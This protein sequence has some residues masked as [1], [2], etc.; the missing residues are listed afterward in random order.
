MSAL[1]T[2][3]CSSLTVFSKSASFLSTPP[4]FSVSSFIRLSMVTTVFLSPSSFA[5]LSAA[6]SAAVLPSSFCMSDI[7]AIMASDAPPPSDSRS[8]NPSAIFSSNSLNLSVA[9][10]SAPSRAFTCAVAWSSSST[11]SSIASMFSCSSLSTASSCLATDRLL[12]NCANCRLYA[13]MPQSFSIHSTVP[14]GLVLTPF[15]FSTNLLP[16]SAE[17]ASES[18]SSLTRAV[19]SAPCSAFR[20][21]TASLASSPLRPSV[22]SRIWVSTPDIA[23]SSSTLVANSSA[24]RLLISSI[25]AKFSAACFRSAASSILF[26]FICSCKRM[27]SS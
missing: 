17:W 4:T 25:L 19:M 18:A 21:A 22:T 7:D 1:P 23:F 14:F 12:T 9:A 27:S 2:S 24:S 8:E 10:L 3:S 16:S 6:S 20:P 13:R 15:R 5:F 11:T 26:C